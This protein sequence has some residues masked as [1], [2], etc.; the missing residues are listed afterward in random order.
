MLL[1]YNI[2][3]KVVDGF[4]KIRGGSTEGFV[5][6]SHNDI[7][8]GSCELTDLSLNTPYS[9]YIAGFTK[10]GNGPWS[11]RINATTGEFG[12]AIYYV[13]VLYR[14]FCIFGLV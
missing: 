11:E 9:I 7:W 5:N 3:Y 2:S 13:F 10:I 6:C 4:T 12:M 8:A 1:G 14:F